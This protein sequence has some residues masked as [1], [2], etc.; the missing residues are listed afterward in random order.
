MNCIRHRARLHRPAL[1]LLAIALAFAPNA[2]AQAHHAARDR[3]HAARAAD[4]SDKRAEAPAAIP[5]KESAEAQLKYAQSLRQSLRG[6]EG[7]ARNASRKTAIA[8]FRAVREY[9]PDNAAACAE[10][11]FRASELLRAENEREAALAELAI[12]RDRGAGTPFRGRALLDI[13]HV[14]RRAQNFPEAL[15]AYEAVLADASTTQRQKD[16]AALWEG[17]V[18]SALKRPEDAHRAWQHVADT[19][20][21]PIDRIKAYDCMTQALIEKGDLDG[22]SALLE[23]CHEALSEAAS[24]ETRVGERVRSALAGMRAH[25]EL[26]RALDKRARSKNDAKKTA[27]Q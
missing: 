4:E 17:H 1:S 24:E 10:S 5:R 2:A 9:F 8:A 21:E 13:A 23:H 25:D 7:E 16:D 22:A 18:Y 15:S 3:V 6:A 20:E 19:A 26:E 11:A 12:A 14:H 27:A